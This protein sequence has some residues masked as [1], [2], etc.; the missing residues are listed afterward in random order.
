MIGYTSDFLAK[1]K[2]KNYLTPTHYLDYIN[3][4]L[5]LIDDKS[6][7]IKRQVIIDFV[8]FSY[9]LFYTSYNFGHIFKN[10]VRKAITWFTENR[11]SYKTVDCTKRAVRTAKNRR[12]RKNISM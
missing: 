1:L 10:I 2:R 3:V 7:S 6:I 4:Y 11:R 5:N 8:L 12:C 9:Y